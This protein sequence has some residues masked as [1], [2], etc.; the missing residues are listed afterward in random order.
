MYCKRSFL[1]LIVFSLSLSTIYFSFLPKLTVKTI[2]IRARTIQ[3]YATAYII[4][5]DCYSLR[6][7]A[8]KE[9]LERVFPD[10]F[11]ITCFLA[12]P[13]NDSRIHTA[14]VLLLKKFSSNLLAF[15]DL[16]SYV[17]PAYSKDDDLAWSFIFEDDVN[18]NPPSQVFLLNYTEA[19][20]E[21]IN[22]TAI[23]LNDGFIY[24]GICGPTF[25]NRTRPLITK[26]TNETLISQK[27]YGFCLHASGITARRSR[28]FWAEISSYRPNPAN[29]A[30]DSQLR[31]YSIRSNKHFYTFGSNF[32]Y[33]PG[34]GHYG[35]AYQDRGRFSTTI[36]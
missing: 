7:N 21:I 26:N 5:A 4:T 20:E 35:V 1:I 32:V 24:L 30:L 22:N 23:Q 29:V 12:T 31:D 25:S 3:K 2:E 28:L 16:W 13:L 9:N 36:I 19:L 15:V 17:I 11:N 27:S 33:P 10:F 14:P 34:A 6:F 18:F 8:T